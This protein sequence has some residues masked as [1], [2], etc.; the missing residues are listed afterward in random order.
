MHVWLFYVKNGKVWARC[1]DLISLLR[2]WNF[3]S[4]KRNCIRQLKAKKFYVVCALWI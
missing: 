2:D 1:T 4:G 3:S